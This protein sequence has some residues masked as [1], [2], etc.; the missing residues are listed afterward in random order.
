[1]QEV[2]S[3][4]D[5]YIGEHDLSDVMSK[6]QKRDKILQDLER[7]T[8]EK[9]KLEKQYSALQKSNTVSVHKIKW[10]TA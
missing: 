6:A 10:S 4:S 1:M 9:E 5:E 7:I 8:A 3:S 2:K